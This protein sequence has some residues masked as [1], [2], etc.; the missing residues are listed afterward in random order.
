MR[1][2]VARV[3]VVVG[4]CKKKH[5]TVSAHREPCHLLMQFRMQHVHQFISWPVAF[6]LKLGNLV[7]QI[8]LELVLRAE[9]QL[10]N[11]GMESIRP[12]HKIELTFGPVLESNPDGPIV[13]LNPAYAVTENGLDLAVDLAE[14]RCGQTSTGH[15]G[16]A[17]LRRPE[18]CFSRETGHFFPASV[19]FADFLDLIP[20]L[21]EFG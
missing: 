4:K 5:R 15:R 20:L 17:A 12:D 18:K 10:A 1:Q 7:T 11:Y 8:F 21:E 16:I 19:D 9:D 13:L 14:D 6:D 2:D 3:G